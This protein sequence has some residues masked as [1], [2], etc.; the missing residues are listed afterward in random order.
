MKI[1]VTRRIHDDQV[2][3]LRQVAEVQYWDQDI[4]P[5]PDQLLELLDGVDGALTLLTDQ[6]DGSVLDQRPSVRVVSNLAVGYDNIDVPAATERGV[7]ICTTPSVLTDTTAEFAV[8][9]IFAVARQIVPAACFVQDGRWE[10]W[11]PLGFLG[12]DLKGTTLGIVGLGRIGR[13]TAEMCQAIGMRVIYADS[14]TDDE[15]FDQ[16]ELDDLLRQSDVVSL[17]TPLT[18]QTRGL[19]NA[20]RLALM[21]DD[22]LLINTARGPVIDTDALVAALDAGRL[23]GVGLDVTDPEPLPADHPLLDFDRVTVVPHI[24]SASHGTRHQM[25]KLAVDNLLAILQGTEPPNCLNPEV[26]QHD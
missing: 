14:E 7:A 10:T 19:I 25:S 6:I 4:P 13:R 2:E 15:Q 16:V 8:T 5:D 22:A 24:A 18:P 12:K 23:A 20:D 1:A 26:L 9:L 21:K 11:Y 3:R 17:H